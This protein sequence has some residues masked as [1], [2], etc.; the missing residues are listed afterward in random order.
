MTAPEK[1]LKL[2]NA[3]LHV[4]LVEAQGHV[5]RLQWEILQMRHAAMVEKLQQ[6]EKEETPPVA[7]SAAEKVMAEIQAARVEPVHT[8]AE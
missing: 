4:A 2:E 7:P 6:V 8:V 5:A 3:Q 1:S